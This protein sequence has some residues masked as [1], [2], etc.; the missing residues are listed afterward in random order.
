MTLSFRPALFL[1]TATIALC[2][3]SALALD[4]DDFVAKLSAA[5]TNGQAAAMTVQNTQ[6]DDDTITLEGVV[7]TAPDPTA[8]TMQLSTMS[9]G[10]MV[11]H[12]ITQT[13]TGGYTVEHATT[14]I[15]NISQAE[16][17]VIGSDFK[18]SGLVVPAD[19]SGETDLPFL[20]Y[21]SASTGPVSLVSDG[22]QIVSY[23]SA[24]ISAGWWSL[25]DMAFSMTLSGLLLDL[26]IAPM[27][28]AAPIVQSLQLQKLQG[29]MVLNGRWQ[30]ETGVLDIDDYSLDLQN[31]GKL[32]VSLG[33]RGYTLD[34]AKDIQA[35]G[36][37]NGSQTAL[38]AQQQMMGLMLKLGLT[39][40]EIRFEDAGITTRALDVFGQMQGINSTQLAAMLPMLA[41]MSLGQFDLPQEMITQITDALGTFLADPKSFVVTM[42]PDA[43]VAFMTL[44]SNAMMTPQNLPATL[45]MS[46][47]ANQ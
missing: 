25:P 2:A 19:L 18:A 14:D 28:P 26:P 7:I 23:N 1:S 39:D 22:Q 11:Y 40:A 36:S 44:V 37:G 8:D 38:A 3:Q 27:A 15:L 30:S 43:P 21:D 5:I 32:N 35:M 20:T 13:D 42:T 12:G 29:D 4:A 16:F 6:L 17:S 45:G 47:T 33:L 10:T 31:V 34:V 41:G 46:I 9:L 24:E